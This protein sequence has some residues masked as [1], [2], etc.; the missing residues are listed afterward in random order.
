M[1][2]G[3]TGVESSSVEETINSGVEF[4]KFVESSDIFALS[5]ELAS[6][7]TTFMKGVAKGLG[8]QLVVTSPT[9]TL[10]NEYDGRVN[11]IHMDCYREDN[12]NQWIKLGIT[13]YFNQD[14][15]VFIEWS[16]RIA[17]ILPERTVTLK[18]EHNYENNRRIYLL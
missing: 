10:I 13:E 7:K 2:Q 18:F 6:G 8:Y 12:I 11:I 5:G 14:Y 1:K 9:F 4:S 15:V 17:D 16:E 3:W